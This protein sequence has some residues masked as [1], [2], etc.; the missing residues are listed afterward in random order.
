[1]KFLKPFAQVGEQFEHR[2][3]SHFSE[4]LAGLW[5]FRGG[6]P[7]LDDLLKFYRGHA[8][9]CGHDEFE[10]RVVAARAGPAHTKGLFR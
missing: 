10:D 5:M 8:R 7:I 3:I 6:D 9:M 2:L 1:M 4:E